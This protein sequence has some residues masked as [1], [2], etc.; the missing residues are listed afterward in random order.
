M[1]KGK[2]EDVEQ[3]MTILGLVGIYD[4]PRVESKPSVLSCHQAGITVHMA[5]GDHPITASVIASQVGI[6][7][8]HA[9][10]MTSME[11][12]AL[13]EDEIDQMEVPL[14]LARCTPESK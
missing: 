12:D 5:T 2:R 6:A 3:D 8:N 7:S 11:F 4:P 10:L 9:K 14:V 13:T 1:K